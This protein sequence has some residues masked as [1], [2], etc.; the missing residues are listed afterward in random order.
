MSEVKYYYIKLKDNFFDKEEIKL[1]ESMKDGYLYSN[2]LLKICLKSLKM[3]GLLMLNEY[4]PYDANMLSAIV[5]HPVGVV[6]EA[7]GL[8]E[9]LGLI[10]VKDSGQIWINNIQELIGKT[11]NEAERKSIYRNKIKSNNVIESVSI[12]KIASEEKEIGKIEKIEQVGKNKTD[13]ID[14]IKQLCNDKDVEL[15]EDE[16]IAIEKWIDFRTK[17]YKTK[18]TEQA[19]KIQVNNFIELLKANKDIV[20]II[21]YVIENTT[22]QNITL[23]YILNIEK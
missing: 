6:K 22:W 18:K 20:S 11:T 1:L 4:I 14:T 3:D 8:F 13:L 7:L 21:D 15:N 17:T 19:I 10:T 9:K 23:K 2:I 16:Y 12:S 5:N